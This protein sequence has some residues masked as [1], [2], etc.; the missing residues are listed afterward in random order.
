MSDFYSPEVELYIFDLD[1]TLVNTE[2]EV[3]GYWKRALCKIG[4]DH[5]IF[6]YFKLV[7]SSSSNWDQELKYIYGDSFPI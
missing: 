1:G 5:E 2:K 6:P 3:L 7:G 4:F